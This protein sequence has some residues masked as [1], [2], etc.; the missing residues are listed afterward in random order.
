MGNSQSTVPPRVVLNTFWYWVTYGTQIGSAVLAVV[1]AGWFLTAWSLQWTMTTVFA[2]A[3]L[4]I[5]AA[6]SCWTARYLVQRNDNG[7]LT[8]GRL[9]FGWIVITI[10]LCLSVMAVVAAVRG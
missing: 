3:G 6:I 9:R 4:A 7:V 8:I 2:A 5:T 1:G 10:M